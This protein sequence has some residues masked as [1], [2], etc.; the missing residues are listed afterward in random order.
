MA[1]IQFLIPSVEIIVILFWMSPNLT[2]REK[3]LTFPVCV[4]E[5]TA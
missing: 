4:T 5:S 2:I 3:I 1:A